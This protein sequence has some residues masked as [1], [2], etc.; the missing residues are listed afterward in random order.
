MNKERLVFEV[1]D[2]VTTPEKGRELVSSAARLM[3]LSPDYSIRR[4]F[5][6]ERAKKGW[7]SR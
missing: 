1:V 7:Y 2:G 6:F 5:D 3:A 4:A